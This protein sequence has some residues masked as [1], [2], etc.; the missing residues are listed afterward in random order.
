MGSVPSTCCLPTKGGS[1][2]S[3]LPTIDDAGVFERYPGHGGSAELVQLIFGPYGL[4]DGVYGPIAKP[5]FKLFVKRL[6]ALQWN[7]YRKRH[8]VDMELISKYRDQANQL[9]NGVFPIV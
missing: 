9:I 1:K 7:T 8:K 5:P 3:E 2:G 4:A 6:V